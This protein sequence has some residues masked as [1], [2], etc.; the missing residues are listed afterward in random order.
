MRTVSDTRTVV[1]VGKRPSSRA[2]ELFADVASGGEATLLSL[3]LRP[4]ATQRLLAEQALA[5]AAERRFVLT[6]ET[7][8]DATTLRD[9]VRDAGTILTAVT[10]GE[11]RR[12]NLEGNA[13]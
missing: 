5:L 12:W 2:E 3:G 7:I 6:A 11:R 13:R 4:T 9:R 1:V 8:P 10:R